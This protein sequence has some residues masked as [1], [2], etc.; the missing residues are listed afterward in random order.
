M[1]AVATASK[2][3]RTWILA[4]TIVASSMAFIDGTVVTIALPAM[5]RGFGA[6]IADMQWVSN[7][8]LLLLGSLILV[9]GGLG[10]RV[11][12][13]LTFMV[14]IVLFALASIF[15]AAAPT[16]QVLIV[17]RLAQGIGAALLSPPSL[18]HHFG[19]LS[20]RRTSAAAPSAPGPPPRRSPPRSVRRSAA[21]SSTFSPGASLSGSTSR[22]PRSRSG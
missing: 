12:R 8:Y 16:V 10:D 19:D 15:C 11:G 18:R 9:G 2:T 6:D 20:I 22:S 21:S 3:Q 17:G 14:G 13:R 7:A 5:Q 4:A 1:S